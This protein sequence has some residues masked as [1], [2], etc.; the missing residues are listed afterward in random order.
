MF[1]DFKNFDP[2]RPFNFNSLQTYPSKKIICSNTDHTFG[3]SPNATFFATKGLLK[4]I[5][6]HSVNVFWLWLL[7]EMEINSNVADRKPWE[8]LPSESHVAFAAFKLYRDMKPPR[9]KQDIA[10]KIGKSI[11]WVNDKAKKWNWEKRVEAYDDYMDQL[12]LES[13]KEEI[14]EMIQRHIQ[15]AI[16]FQKVLLLPAES[17]LE[18][19][20]NNEDFCQLSIEKHFDKVIDA[21][22]VLNKII[23]IERKSLG[24]PN[25]IT[26]TDVT[27]NH[28]PITVTLPPL[29]V[30]KNEPNNNDSQF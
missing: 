11:K 23:D 15:Q 6:L 27:S 1:S 18:R 29:P 20:S 24:E 28:K 19:L 4:M 14:K 3:Q 12:E 8:R 13:R 22:Q 17:F 7:M 9:N 5:I 2:H 10:E 26:K 16:L 25:E 21:A 30:S